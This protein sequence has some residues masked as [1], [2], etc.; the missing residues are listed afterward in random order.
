[1][2]IYGDLDVSVI[3]TMPK[4]R[5]PVKTLVLPEVKRERVMAM[6]RK[7]LNREHGI[8]IVYPLIEESEASAMRDATRMAEHWGSVFPDQRTAL[9]HGR[10]GTKDKENIMKKFRQRHIDILVC[11]TVVEV[12]I[13]IP[14][15]TMIIVEN[16]EHFGL[17]QLHQL[18]GRVGRGDSPALCVLITSPERTHVASKRLKIMEKTTDGFTI[19]EEDLRIRGVGDMLGVRQSGLPPFRIGDVVKQIDIM[20]EARRIAEELA[21]TLSESDFE[22]LAGRIGRRFDDIRELAGIA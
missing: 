15:A 20:S 1:M 7:E 9:L 5:Q 2:V 19:A 17:S 3:D 18:R 14:H 6:M 4:G 13:D 8:F 16:A 11:T 21:G 10:M 22:K 12:G